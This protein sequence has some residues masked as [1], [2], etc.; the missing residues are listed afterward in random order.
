MKN[1]RITWENRG[2]WLREV[3]VNEWESGMRSS[4]KH[5]NNN[6]KL[7]QK[8]EGERLA[9]KPTY[10]EWNNE[11]CWGSEGASNN[12]KCTRILNYKINPIL[13]G[14]YWN[15]WVKNRGKQRCLSPRFLWS[16]RKKINKKCEKENL[17]K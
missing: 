11:D 14:K 8:K 2:L 13:W 17:I 5:I 6:I 4:N 1:R 3:L 15:K 16:T 10:W 7:N 12:M 9:T